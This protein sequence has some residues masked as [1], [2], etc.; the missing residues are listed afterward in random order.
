MFSTQINI[1][2]SGLVYKKSIYVDWQMRSEISTKANL[3]VKSFPAEILGNAGD[4]SY[5]KARLSSSSSLRRILD[6]ILVSDKGKETAHWSETSSGVSLTFNIKVRTI[7][8]QIL[9]HVD[10]YKMEII[11]DRTKEM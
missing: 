2:A 11:E 10:R 5:S 8:K 4:H 6:S 1:C 3:F 9:Y 7:E